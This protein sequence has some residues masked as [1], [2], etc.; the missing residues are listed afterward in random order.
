MKALLPL[1]IAAAYIISPADIVSDVVPVLGQLDEALVA[2][3]MAIATQDISLKE[4]ACDGAAAARSVRI[5]APVVAAA[6]AG[7]VILLMK[8]V[9]R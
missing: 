9:I 1:L 7:I 3:I 4:A 8:N 6:L 5:S 2:L